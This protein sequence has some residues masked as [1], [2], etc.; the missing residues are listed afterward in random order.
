MKPGESPFIS[1]TLLLGDQK[2]KLIFVHKVKRKSGEWRY[3]MK[4]G[5]IGDSARMRAQTI[6][7]V[8]LKR[9]SMF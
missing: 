5:K 7:S 8:D 2:S 6:K 4:E 3:E 9:V 1:Q